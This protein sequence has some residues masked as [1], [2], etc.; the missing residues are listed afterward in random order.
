MDLRGLILIFLF[1]ISTKCLAVGELNV[2][3][4]RAA[5][6]AFSSVALSDEWSAFN[7][8]GGLARIKGYQAG[9]YFENRFLVKEISLKALVVTIPVWKGSFGLILLHNGFS[10][11][12]E[13][14]GGVAYGMSLGKYFSAGVQLN[15]LRI[16]QAEGYGNKNV[17]SFEIGAQFKASEHLTLGVHI[18]NPVAT[19]ISRNSS[20]RLPA[21]IRLG[22]L[23]KISEDLLTTVEAEKD[24]LHKPVIRAGVEYH[25]VKPLFARVGILT[26]PTTFTFGAGLEFGSFKLDLASGYHLI[27]GYSPQASITYRFK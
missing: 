17:F 26:N 3:G 20:D 12:S 19:R 6:M 21:L 25:L 11:Y 15:C 10:L 13:I 9:I 1:V 7:N 16:S 23:W 14:K 5:G 4:A 18:V 2:I 8:P 24:L 27:L 22:L